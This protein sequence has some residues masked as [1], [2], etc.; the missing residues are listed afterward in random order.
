MWESNPPP[1]V[2]S[3]AC[4]DTDGNFWHREQCKAAL[5]D[6]EMDCGF[7]VQHL[8]NSSGPECAAASAAYFMKRHDPST[9]NNWITSC[10]LTNREL[11][12][13]HGYPVKRQV[14]WVQH[15]PARA[16]SSREF[17]SARVALTIKPE[18]HSA[19]AKPLAHYSLSRYSPGTS[20]CGTSCV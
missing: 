8:L 17:R 9:E 13:G 19:T 11:S 16:F 12:R 15:A 2:N 4:R 6:C 10:L 7:F 14:F 5:M 18:S 1:N 3:T 20:S